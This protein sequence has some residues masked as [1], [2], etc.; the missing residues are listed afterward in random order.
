MA[1]AHQIASAEV[2]ICYLLRGLRHRIDYDR[3]PAGRRRSL[4]REVADYLIPA[5]IS[6]RSTEEWVRLV[7]QRFEI[8]PTGEGRVDGDR[9]FDARPAYVV[10]PR[11]FLP[12]GTLE[13]FGH[14]QAT[15]G[16]EGTAV[17]RWDH[18]TR[19][20]DFA[21]LRLAL[22]RNPALVATF[23]M[24]PPT[25]GEETIF[26]PYGVG[27]ETA[28]WTATLPQRL[29]T[30]RSFTTVLTL[31]SP[32]A[33]GADHKS[34]NVTMF[35]RQR[36]VDPTTGETY[37][38]PFIS[39][40][41]WRGIWRDEAGALTCRDVGLKLT[42][43]DTKVAHA[44]MAGGTIEAGADGA[45]VDLA[46]RRQARRILPA[47]DLFAGVMNQQIMRGILRVHDAI[48]VCR[49][50]AWL[51]H[52]RLKPQ[53]DGAPMSYETFRAALEPA[54]NLTQLRLLTRHAHRDLEGSE[55]V[56]MLTETEVLLPGA[57]L[58]H[59]FQLIELDGVSSL[60]RSFLSRVLSAFRDNAFVG[61]GN[62]RGLGAVAFDPYQP[63]A[64][65]QV[66]PSEDE[67]LAHIEQHREEIRTFLMGARMK[68][69]PA[70]P[71]PPKARG[72]KSTAG[73]VAPS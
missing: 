25:E 3:I 24:N 16:P 23:A 33:H 9:T 67:Y 32:C 58:V 29:Q 18:L 15:T 53:R 8:E 42:E 26:K 17:V 21:G 30:P 61:A 34:G 10:L 68:D 19:V 43:I 47:W 52:D 57:Q 64:E 60:S 39:G 50:N 44:L 56:Q 1:T 45:S 48:L 27:C 14:A 59:A 70:S 28:R 73:E 51:L 63:G 46:L 22:D 65:A 5:S 38:A 31:T 12:P 69:K 20:I 36:Y 54:D 11:M 40:N 72:K 4:A 7:C 35:R 71:A 41:A 62:A 6:A 37:L 66:L 13:L 55:G 49:E 2:L